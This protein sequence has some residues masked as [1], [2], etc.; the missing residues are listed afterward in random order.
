MIITTTQ[1]IE[2]YR[3]TDYK[4]MVQGII[5]RTPTIGQGLVGSIGSL[6]G[7]NNS[8]Y[9]E[10][11]HQGREHAYNEMVKDAQEKQAN[12]IIGVSYDSSEILRTGTEVICY[13]TAV[14]IEPIA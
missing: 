10:M 4:G 12:A 11:C 3:I 9:A 2:G 5:V 14:T 6:F 7:G 1:C 13:G 8:A